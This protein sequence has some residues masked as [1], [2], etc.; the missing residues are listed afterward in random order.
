MCSYLTIFPSFRSLVI[1]PSRIELLGSLT[2]TRRSPILRTR[3]APACLLPQ[4]KEE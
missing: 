3:S 1:G 4:G 2:G